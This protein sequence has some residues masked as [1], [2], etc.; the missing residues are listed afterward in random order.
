MRGGSDFFF[1]QC[2]LVVAFTSMFCASGLALGVVLDNAA[3]IYV[4]YK[5]YLR[6]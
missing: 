3:D 5:H 4:I 1:F 6:L 2:F